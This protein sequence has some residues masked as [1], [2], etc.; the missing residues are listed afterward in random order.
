MHDMCFS[1]LIYLGRLSRVMGL[2]S[3]FMDFQLVDKVCHL[4]KFR[5]IFG[6]Y[7]QCLSRESHFNHF[8]NN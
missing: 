1:F 8:T 6:V 2:C 4:D 3:G 5:D 7:N